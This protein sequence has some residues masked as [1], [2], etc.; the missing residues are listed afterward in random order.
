M[1]GALEFGS[2]LGSAL[3]GDLVI[4]MYPDSWEDLKIRSPT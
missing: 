3:L 1:F 2:K 4:R